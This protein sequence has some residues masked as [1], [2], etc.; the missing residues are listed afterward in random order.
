MTPDI[1]SHHREIA[2]YV[3]RM[4]TWNRL[5]TIGCAILIVGAIVMAT[6]A[7]LGAV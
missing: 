1:R 6:R 4:E 5:I 2:R 7:V 3:R